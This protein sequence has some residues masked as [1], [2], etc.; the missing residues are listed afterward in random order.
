MS[1]L[2]PHRHVIR[3]NPINDPRTYLVSTPLIPYYYT[4]LIGDA[5]KPPTLLA[6]ASFTG[7]A[8]IGS[9]YLDLSLFQVLTSA[10]RRR[11]LHP[12]RGRCSVVHK[13]EQLVST[14]SSDSPLHPDEQP[15]SSS[16]RSV[17]NF[18]ID[19][20]R[21]PPST[22]A[23]GI[24]WQVSQATSLM[25]IVFQMST[26]AGNAHQGIMRYH[27]PKLLIS[28]DLQVY[29]WRMEA[30]VLWEVRELRSP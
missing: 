17:R 24:H 7:M 30:A 16:Y 19:V 8:V 2:H 1:S 22:S 18:V 3:N 26:A 4:Q 14:L 20:S 13:P 21:M 27:C 29:G 5:R 12:W 9:I 11:S 6:A 25:N 23:T 28:P 10:I 15:F